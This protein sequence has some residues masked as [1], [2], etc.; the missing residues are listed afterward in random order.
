M[1]D[2]RTTRHP[3]LRR[4]LAIG[5]AL[6]VA[7][8]WLVGAAV[9]G[10][11]LQHEI[12]EVSDSALQEV[13]QRILPLA[14]SELLSRD[15]DGGP[16]RMPPVGPHREYISY[17]VRD[18]NGKELLQ[19]SDADRAKIP[20]GLSPGFHTTDHLR[21]YTETAVQGTILVTAAENIGHRK[22]AL[23]RSIRALLVPLAALVPIAIG[24]AWLA[25]RLAFGPV[26]AFRA[27]LEERDRGNLTPV[28]ATGLPDELTPVAAAVNA[29][30]GRLRGALEAERSFTANS[31]HELRTPVA[32][33]L[34]QTQRLVAELPDDARRERAQA[35][36]NALRRLAR[37]SEKLLQLAKA[38]GGGL[39]TTAPSP[40]GPVLALVVDE[41][42]R[43]PGAR[44]RIELSIAPDDMPSDLDPDAFAILS[45]NLIE[46]AV[47]H[48]DPDTPVKVALSSGFLE[49]ENR[50]PVVP[51]ERLAELTRPFERGP[52]DA[53][54]SGLGLAI[55]SAIGR[56][57][58]LTLEFASP[59]PGTEDGF[60]ARVMLSTS[61][62][63]S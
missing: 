24:V 47:R 22:A 52:T 50:G 45:R 59:V 36:E 33:A 29:L 23:M 18:A 53:E 13:A 46:N 39:I 26:V 20:R 21:T 38:E 61:R 3:S 31:A 44:G 32:A 40:L 62:S 49:V 57:A 60:Q 41:V 63:R 35:I 12:E 42:G 43:Q 10:L 28:D 8:L 15:A 48:G 6:G 16:Q 7:V 30:I 54:G 11:L 51:A 5:L 19:S 25:V 4:R 37:L 27:A 1:T 58:G 14:Y 56:G 17:V 2:T 55:A 9:A 34:A